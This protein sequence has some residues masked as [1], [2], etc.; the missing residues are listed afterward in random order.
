MEASAHQAAILDFVRTGCGHGLVEATA[1]AGKTTT[2]VMVAR[3]LVDE[4]GLPP[5][6]VAFLAFNRSAAAQLKER[7]PAG[8]DALTLHALGRRVLVGTHGRVELDEDKYLRL[9]ASCGAPE[10]ARAGL[11]AAAAFARLDLV[12]TP[13]NL[14]S[15][16][17]KYGLELPLEPSD[18]ALYLDEMLTASTGWPQVDFTDLLYLPVRLALPVPSYDFV[19]VDEAQDMSRLSLA[20]VQRLVSAG[21]R[22][23]FVGDASQAIYGFAGA[24]A[25][26]LDRVASA[27]S[28]T[29]LPLSVSY[30]CPTRH[31]VL[32]RRLSPRMLP[33]VG[34]PAG[35]V[36]VT[37]MARLAGTLTAGDLVLSRTNGPLLDVALTVAAAGLP[38]VV[39]GDDSLADA[40]Q[41]VTRLAGAGGAV[42]RHALAA[43]LA[44]ETERLER[45]M[46]L[47][48]ELPGALDAARHVH[49]AAAVAIAA[50]GSGDV[51]RVKAAVNRLFER[52]EET[53]HVLLSTVHKAKGREARRV[54]LLAPEDL[55]IGADGR[56]TPQDAP[57]GEPDP[58]TVDD[59]A[60]ANV[61]FVALTRAKSALVLVEK[62]PSAIRRRLQRHE[63][64]GAPGWLARWWDDVL[65]LALTMSVQKG[66]PVISSRHVEAWRVQDPRRQARG[67]GR[68]GGRRQDRR[69]HDLG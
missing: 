31:V 51:T 39:L 64:T 44:S 9:A 36:S 53:E 6:R 69:S 52:Q 25:R 24:D 48:L 47:D 27:T 45:S 1:G 55:G 50:A 46:P 18:A 26:S 12:R 10:H 43:S 67:R 15:L 57:E 61:L 32:A 54:F 30:R 28:A 14:P 3:L 40:S 22:A 60:E 21:A 56:S 59:Q 11:S 33:E 42:D 4:V 17:G 63:D 19:C 5:G 20:F 62:E 65:R 37:S 49:Q 2:L 34:A 13:V 16:L 38:A 35:H 66:E 8:V 68:G 23:L 29:R 7:L 58:T 41:L